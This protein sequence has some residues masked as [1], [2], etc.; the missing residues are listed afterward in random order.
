MNQ[1]EAHLVY[2]QIK[3]LVMNKTE[4]HIAYKTKRKS[5]WYAIKNYPFLKLV[6]ICYD[7]RID[8]CERIINRSCTLEF[9]SFGRPRGA[10]LSGP[11]FSPSVP[12]CCDVRGVLGGPAIGGARFSVGSMQSFQSG[13]Q[14]GYNFLYYCIHCSY[15]TKHLNIIFGL[16]QTHI[17]DKVLI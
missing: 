15:Y 11:Y 5:V 16:R 8:F 2:N 1:T 13:R 17:R 4:V 9:S 3:F 7:L 6:S 12:Y 14:I 10:H